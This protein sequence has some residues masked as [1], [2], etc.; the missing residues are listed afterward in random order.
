MLRSICVLVSIA[1]NVGTILAIDR[2]EAMSDV[3]GIYYISQKRLNEQKSI[4]M[5]PLKSHEHRM[6]SRRSSRD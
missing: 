6:K 1:T 2:I 5:Q 4:H 3:H